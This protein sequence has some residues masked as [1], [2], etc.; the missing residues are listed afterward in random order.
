MNCLSDV[1]AWLSLHFINFNESKTEIIVLCLSDSFSTCKI[2]L[3]DL[4]SS[5]KPWLKNLGVV[6]DDSLK[7]DKQINTV[8]KSCFFQL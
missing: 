5:V 1:K 3:G 8:V 7:F 4:S 6:F 2:Y